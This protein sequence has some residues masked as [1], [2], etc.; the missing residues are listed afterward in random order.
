M[1]SD[2]LKRLY[3]SKLYSGPAWK[4]RVE[5]MPMD[6]V[7]AIY[8]S[9]LVDGEMPNHDEPPLITPVVPEPRLELPPN[10]RGPHANEDQFPMY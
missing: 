10:G 7:T 6:Q 2:D 9:H 4:K 8:L 3:I 5:K 1:S